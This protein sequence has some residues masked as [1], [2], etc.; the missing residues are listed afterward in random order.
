MSASIQLAADFGN[1]KEMYD[2]I[3][4]ALGPTQCKTA[5]LKS[6]TGET[7]T[8]RNAQMNR[9]VEHY[10]ELYARETKISDSAINAIE[11][12]STM[13]ELDVEPTLEELSKAI[14]KL[15]AGKAPGSDGIPP[16]LIKQC[17]TT[18]LHPL[19]EILCQCWKEGE[20]PQDMRDSKITTLYKNK[21]DRSDCNNYRGIS[22]LSIVG[23]VFARVIL[24][25]LQVLADRI[26]PESQCGFRSQRSTIDMIFSLR[27]LQEKCREQRMPLF[28]SFI[29]LTKAFDLVSRD[30]LFKVLPKI[31]C[32]PKLLNMIISFHKDMKGTVLFNG[33][34]SEPFPIRN[35]VK[36]GCVLAPT[37]FGIFFSLVLKHA[38]RDSLEGVYLRSRS[39][40]KLFNLARLR[41]NSK[42]SE[43]VIRDLLFADDA[44]LA[45]HSEQALQNLM[46]K[47]SNA[48]ND[49]GL[50]ISLKKTEILAQDA[51]TVPNIKIG[52]HPLKV[53]SEFTY[54]GSTVTSNLNLDSEL[55]KRI[56]KAA[57]TMAR[58]TN[59]VWKNPDLTLKT[60]MAVYKAC[61]L[62]ILLYSS[63]AWTTYARHEKRLNVFHLRNI[64]RILCISWQDRV[65][66][67]EILSR[68]GLPSIYT[69]LK[70]RRLRWL[71]HVRRMSD[72]RIPKALL[73]G[74]LS[75]GSRARGRPKLRYKDVIKN[76]MKQTGIDLGTW[77]E[78]SSDRPRWR[79]TLAQHLK[80]G[81]E[82]LRE[83]WEE[84]R[85][86]R[87]AII[88]TSQAAVFTCNNCGRTC[89][90]RIG[91]HSHSRRCR[92][93]ED[94]H[95]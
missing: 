89:L 3:K 28:L 52:D 54:L 91:L 36:Q 67:S 51:A 46:T 55:D 70:Q 6:T 29:D 4:K 68:A 14:D 76:D 25:R 18:L 88:N 37:L 32:P 44:A 90:S 62:S 77:E 72:S 75:N 64:R 45:T 66:N 79:T 82:K 86:K 22:L 53:V 61:V 83:T 78:T 93:Q 13:E 57:S 50:T 59:K 24:A 21:G 58:L 33:N 30:G 10:S 80:T 9:W 94:T 73:Y 74:E 95:P 16:D 47:F 71:G 27:Q 31:G 84:R 49:F 48:C 2:G 56:G 7:I 5:P 20:V 34:L 87:K 23:K 12:L 92:P 1:I 17:K 63:E 15:A 40:G 11:S 85:Q 60:K 41:A 65:T 39:D 19:Y 81:E 8:D 69:L 26:Y 35:G 38:F 43:Q 42:V